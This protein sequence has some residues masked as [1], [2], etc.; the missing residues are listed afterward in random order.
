MH[1]KGINIMQNANFVSLRDLEDSEIDAVAGGW[2]I[3]IVLQYILGIKS[4]NGD[5]GAPATGGGAGNNGG[6]DDD[7]AAQQTTSES[8]TGGDTDTGGEEPR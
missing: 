7:A 3:P 4:C 1:V 8:D 6:D 2:T 5:C